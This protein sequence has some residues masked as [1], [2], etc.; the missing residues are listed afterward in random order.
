MWAQT[1]DSAP[2]HELGLTLGRMVATHRTAGQIRFDLGGGNA[3][4]ANY[5]LRIVDGATAALY[6]EVHFLAN[7]QRL[8]TATDQ[9]LTRDVA[10]LFVLPGLRVKFLPRGAV[11]PYIAAGGGY[12]LF[13][14]SVNRLDGRPNSAPRTVN[15]G[16]F[17]FGGG[18]DVGLWRFLKLRAEI[19]DF[20]TGSPAFNTPVAGGQHNVVIGGGFVLSFR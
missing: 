8:V 1:P 10:S 9:T 15:R 3:W 12:A 16:A 13:E 19:R 7:P 5:G 11:S 18:V 17:G 20:Y 2:K 6:G 14:H 4:Q